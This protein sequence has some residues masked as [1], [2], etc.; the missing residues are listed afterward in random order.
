MRQA[1][2]LI[3][4]LSSSTA[5]AQEVDF[6]RVVDS[7]YKVEGGSHTRHPF[8]VLS[9]KCKG[10]D[11]C[12]AVCYRTVRNNYRRWKNAGNP[13]SFLKYLQSRYAPTKGAT[14]D[15]RHMNSVWLKNMEFWYNR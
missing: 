13:G 9:V 5:Y 4:L 10:Y 15:P 1:I 2:V 3:L 7:I 6:N 11:E 12:R 14:N 8:G